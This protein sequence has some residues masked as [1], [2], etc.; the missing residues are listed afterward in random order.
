[1]RHGFSTRLGGTS[2]GIYESMNLCF[3]R[4]DNTEAVSRNF[5]LIGAELGIAPED[6]VYAK[7]T[8][9][10]DIMEAKPR[11]RGMGVVRPRDYD[12]VDGLVTNTAGIALVITCADCV[13]VFLVDPVRRAIG[14]VHSG[15][16]GTVQN[17][18]GAAVKRLAELYGSAPRGIKAFIGPSVCG[19][20][21]EVGEDVAERFAEHY[22]ED[23][24]LNGILKPIEPYKGKFLLNLHAANKINL[25]GAGV[26]AENIGVTDICTC[27][28]PRLLFSH[29]ASKG[30]RGGQCAF[31]QLIR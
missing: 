30:L 12:G 19:N 26:P 28:N 24:F 3:T 29:R 9:G 17:I 2:T 16:R 8:H 31:L 27:C 20:C 21:Y 4:G 18:A 1:M 14:L 7:Q 22:G 11:H 10:D 25:T 6:M 23:A 15:W 13:P 5:E